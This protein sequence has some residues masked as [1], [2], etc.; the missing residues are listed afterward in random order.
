MTFTDPHILIILIAFE[1]FNSLLP[2]HLYAQEN[3]IMAVLL[4]LSLLLLNI[5]RTT[6]HLS[7]SSTLYA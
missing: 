2:Q 5:I 7:C 4:L 1:T 6:S 3:N